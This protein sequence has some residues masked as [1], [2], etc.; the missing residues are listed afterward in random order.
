[1][2]L[3]GDETPVLD[4][5][6]KPYVW[7]GVHRAFRAM[8]EIQFA[9]GA[10]RVMPIHGDGTGYREW[11]SARKAIDEFTFAPLDARV[12]AA[13]TSLRGG[14]RVRMAIEWPI[15]RMVA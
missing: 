12:A 3:S 7:E 6:L 5:P 4:C 1:M 13:P 11:S 8:A 2:T 10:I 9:A 15:T 14:D